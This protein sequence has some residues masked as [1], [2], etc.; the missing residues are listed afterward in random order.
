MSASTQPQERIT[1]RLLLDIVQQSLAERLPRSWAVGTPQPR[2]APDSGIDATLHLLAPQTRSPKI[3]VEVKRTVEPRDVSRLRD[4]LDPT[5]NGG[6]WDIG[7]VAARYLSPSVRKRLIEAGLSFIDATGNIY[8]R[9]DNPALFIADRGLDNDPW[10]GPGRPRGTLKG[11]P[12][13]QVVRALL[14]APGPWRMRELVA[15]AQA[16]TGSAY[17]VIEFLETEELVVRNDDSTVSVPD[18][19]PVLRRWSADYEFLTTN[20]VSRWIAPRGVDS[21]IRA[22]LDTDPA[23]Y[24]VTGSVAAATWAP[25]APA[26]SVMAYANNVS[27]IAELWG[28]RATDTGANVLLAEPA[29]AALTRGAKQRADGLTVAAPAQVAADLLT[30]PGRAPSEAEE[31]ID[32]MVAHERDWR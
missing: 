22:A 31:L 6:A 19:V 10:R 15:S 3:A 13:A 4:Q 32:W 30:G 26:R 11:A 7:L 25:Y 21:V 12:A 14:D 2:T 18:W 27:E 28:L 20:A 9:S 23:A 29:Y 16:S 17:R 8:V 1:E 24:V 5:Q